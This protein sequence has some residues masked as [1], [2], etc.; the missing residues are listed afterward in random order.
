MYVASLLITAFVAYQF[1]AGV[2]ARLDGGGK[3]LSLSQR[4]AVQYNDRSSLRSDGDTPSGLQYEVR[5]TASNAPVCP[6]AAAPAPAGQP[7]AAAAVAAPP[8]QPAPPEGTPSDPLASLITEQLCYA[9]GDESEICAYD[10]PL[11]VDVAAG[12]LVVVVPDGQ[13]IRGWDNTGR[14]RNACLD[15]RQSESQQNCGYAQPAFREPPQRPASPADCA[16]PEG[17][18][19]HS[20]CAAASLTTPHAPSERGWGPDVKA[21]WIRE[22]E[23]SA[24][25]ALTGAQGEGAAVSLKDGS[26]DTVRTKASGNRNATRDMVAAVMKRAA[27]GLWGKTDG[28]RGRYLQAQAPHGAY[29]G[30]NGSDA[31]AAGARQGGRRLTDD[32]SKRSVAWLDGA[33][34][35]VPMMSGWIDHPWHSA[36]AIMALWSAKRHNASVLV[37][38]TGQD[39]A[40]KG[41]PQIEQLLLR[42]RRAAAASADG[43]QA[44]ATASEWMA[45]STREA[46]GQ[47]AGRGPKQ[48]GYRI[49]AGG[50][51]LPP[52]DYVAMLQGDDAKPRDGGLQSFSPWLQGNWPILTQPQSVALVMP[53]IRKLVAKLQA[54]DPSSG[55]V[56]LVCARRGAVTGLQPRLFSGTADAAAYRTA[57]WQVA[58]VP[59]VPS[60]ESAIIKAMEQTTAASPPAAGAP[61]HTAGLP[62]TR[63]HDQY[64]P[65]KITV[66]SRAGTRGLIPEAGVSALLDA[67]GLA[68]EWVSDMGSRSWES[69]VALMAGTGIVLAS[70]GAALTNIM[71]MPLHAVVIEVSTSR[72]ASPLFAWTAC[73]HLPSRTAI[74]PLPAP[75]IACRRFP[76]L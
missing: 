19:S 49:T 6:S 12:S 32:S 55:G 68:W 45:D 53:T 61:L 67:T 39:A 10:G 34:W 17:W 1:G 62:Y 66:L 8:S 73:A 59:L 70:H 63:P 7:S 56:P 29:S 27:Q 16:D 20:H 26:R 60:D 71:Y 30:I 3:T 57:A 47:T 14:G 25:A 46:G 44:G 5:T 38:P 65:R 54:E 43:T 52:M 22:M 37:L 33:L 69:Q 48:R 50:I 42:Q 72:P 74:P 40:S 13:T 4:A 36:S 15:W 58:G 28:D 9:A 2:P 75:R 18:A 23:L 11:C 24:F 51:A 21:F 35:V 41:G 31:H 76:T 64:P